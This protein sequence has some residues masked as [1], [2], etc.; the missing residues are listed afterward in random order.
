MANYSITNPQV[1]GSLGLVWGENNTWGDLR[2]GDVLVRK[3]RY[4]WRV[5]I[6]DTNDN[7][8]DWTT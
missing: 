2:V 6:W 4:F 5:R 8:S 1:W 7:I 3:L